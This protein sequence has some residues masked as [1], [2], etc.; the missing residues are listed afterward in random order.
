MEFNILYW[1][2]SIRS[3]A[4]DQIMVKIFNDF[5]GTKGQI[6]VIIGLILLL[7]PITRKTGVCVLASYM[8]AYYIGD[9]ILKDLIARPRPCM[10]DETVQLIISRPSS[11]SCPSVHSMLAFASASAVYC[12][13]KKGGAVLLVFAALI[14]FSR[15]YFFVHFPT[16]VLLGAALG[17]LIGSV[18]SY[19]IIKDDEKIEN[20]RQY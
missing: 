5:V 13:Y 16:D 6:W 15:M 2:Q 1:I 8:I 9:G 12:Y 14:S 7:I 3:E 4:L 11:F 10:V 19:M 17:I 18:V 20:R